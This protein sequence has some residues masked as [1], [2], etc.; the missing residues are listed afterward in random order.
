MP[1]TRDVQLKAS[2]L[3]AKAKGLAGPS[4]DYLNTQA[5][6]SH[7]MGDHSQPPPAGECCST[8]KVTGMRDLPPSHQ[9]TRVVSILHGTSH[10]EKPHLVPAS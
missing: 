1:S 6:T 10:H 7:I 3:L 9:P 5:K 4:P 2:P 8:Y